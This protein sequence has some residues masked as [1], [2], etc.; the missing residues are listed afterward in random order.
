MDNMPEGFRFWMKADEA[1]AF[2]ACAR[3]VGVDVRAA[4]IV[5]ACVWS[6]QQGRYLRVPQPEG[7][8]AIM[9]P[10]PDLT[11]VWESYEGTA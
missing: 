4:A 11:R 6:S 7:D 5:E 2:E 3:A 9:S 8:L 1:K 10:E